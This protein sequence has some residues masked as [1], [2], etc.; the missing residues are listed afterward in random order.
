MPLASSWGLDACPGKM[1]IWC[2]GVGLLAFLIYDP[3]RSLLERLRVLQR[4]SAFL[5][6]VA[7][8]LT[9]TSANAWQALLLHPLLI[10]GHVRI[11]SACSKLCIDQ[12]NAAR[13][14]A[15]IRGLG[16]YIR[17]SRSFLILWSPLCAS[18]RAPTLAH[19]PCM[20]LS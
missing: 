8:H 6:Y 17:K 16:R 2:R 10:R 14:T 9:V 19:A 4:K 11:S 15:G 5:E 12:T 18:R 13:K 20:G 1:A 3:L 7:R